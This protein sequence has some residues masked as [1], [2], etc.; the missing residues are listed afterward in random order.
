MNRAVR[1]TLNLLNGM[2]GAALAVAIATLAGETPSAIA[3]TAVVAPTVSPTNVNP[4]PGTTAPVRAPTLTVPT[5]PSVGTISAPVHVLAPP[6]ALTAAPAGAPSMAPASRTIFRDATVVTG[7][8]YTRTVSIPSSGTI[9]IIAELRG[10]SDATLSF[11]PTS[12]TGGARFS[13]DLR[14]PAANRRHG[15][16][17]VGQRLSREYQVTSQQV[18]NGGHFIVSVTPIVATLGGTASELSFEINLK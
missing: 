2:P 10:A 15:A 17:L 16:T 11:E 3:A 1:M 13:A 5:V 6:V 9:Q 12:T 14:S 4:Q 7:Q 8:R 18:A